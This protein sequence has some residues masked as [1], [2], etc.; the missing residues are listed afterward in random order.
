MPWVDPTK[1]P[2]DVRAFIEGARSSRG[3]EALGIFVAGTYV[4]GTGLR[5]G[6]NE[7][8]GE[9][10]YWIDEAHEG[11]GLVTRTC[12][13]LIEHAFAE[14]GLHRVTICAAPE[15]ARSRAIPERLGFTE[16]GRLREAE[17]GG[18]GYH[19]LVVYGLL[20]Q[21]WRSE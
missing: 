13:A 5:V 17:R 12:A 21:E 1:G 10:G 16:E 2:D 19:D 6:R 8:D 4:G 15:N 20:A 7:I 11:A 18:G 14:M 3:L 9:L